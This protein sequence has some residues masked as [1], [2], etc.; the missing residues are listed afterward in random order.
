[1][2]GAGLD[3]EYVAA[4]DPDVVSVAVPEMPEGVARPPQDAAVC[5]NEVTM[6]LRHYVADGSTFI[7]GT[8]LIKG[9]A[10]RLLWK[11]AAEYVNAGRTSFT[12]REARLDPTLE[13]P[14]FRDNFESR[15]ILLKRRLE[16]RGAPLRITDTG[17]GRFG[18]LVD[19]PISLE[20]VEVK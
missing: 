7:D 15:L 2:V 1:L 4:V 19:A 11:V 13:L 18:L 20:R 16:E 17:R 9:V 12:N 6:R 14:A 8:Y 5:A 10:G 3:R